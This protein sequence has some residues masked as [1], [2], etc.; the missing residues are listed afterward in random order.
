M[1]ICVLA[2]LG[3]VWIVINF[4]SV[5]VT[6]LLLELLSKRHITEWV[7]SFFNW[8]GRYTLELYILHLLIYYFFNTI[9]NHYSIGSHIIVAVLIALLLCKP[10]HEFIS[11][12]TRFIMR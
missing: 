2:D 11:R 3:N 1:F 12:I 9:D 8:L 7:L 6:S 4:V 10:S 5:I